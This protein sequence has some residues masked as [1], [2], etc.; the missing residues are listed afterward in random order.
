MTATGPARLRRGA[1]RRH[2]R[3]EGS[4]E[5]QRGAPVD[6]EGSGEPQRGAPV[7]TPAGRPD[8]D[9]VEG[10]PLSP[11]AFRHFGIEAVLVGAAVRQD[12]LL[13][14]EGVAIWRR[15]ELFFFQAEDGIRDLYVTGVQT[16]AL[17]I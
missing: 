1:A 15:L 9:R 17:P 12:G 6:R 11:R 7:N 14:R 8:R 4:G 13:R 3:P 10:R 16:C 2:E 5:P